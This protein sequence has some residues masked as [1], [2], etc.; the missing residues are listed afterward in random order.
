LELPNWQ[1][2]L[3]LEERSRRARRDEVVLGEERAVVLG[4]FEQVQ[5]LVVM[6]D[7]PD[8][9]PSAEFVHD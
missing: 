7:Q 5:L 9:F 4:P 1:A 8:L 6:G 2:E 3:V